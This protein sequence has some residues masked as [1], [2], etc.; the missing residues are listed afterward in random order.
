MVWLFNV[1]ICKLSFT[2]IDTSCWK[3][4]ILL[5]LWGLERLKLWRVARWQH[6]PECLQL[7]CRLFGPFWCIGDAHSAHKLHR[8]ALLCTTFQRLLECHGAWSCG[9]HP[10]PS[11][12]VSTGLLQRSW[13]VQE[14]QPLVLVARLKVLLQRLGSSYEFWRTYMDIQCKTEGNKDTFEQRWS[15]ISVHK[16]REHENNFAHSKALKAHFFLICATCYVAGSQGSRGQRKGTKRAL[17]L[18]VWRKRQTLM[19]K[20]TWHSNLNKCCVGIWRTTVKYDYS[21]YVYNIL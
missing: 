11:R 4:C 8:F 3:T 9:S 6:L 15:C 7:G 2:S 19:C 14:M 21:K 20:T 1:C 12:L 17:P 18:I 13:L 10:Q 5:L 16:C